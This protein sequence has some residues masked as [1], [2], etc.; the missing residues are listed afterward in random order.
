MA[1][2]RADAEALDAADPLAGFRERFVIDDPERLY[3]DGNSLGRLPV[4]TRERL[5][6][7]TAQW[8]TE[9]VSGWPEWLDAPRRVGDLLAEHVLGAPAGT[10][11]A[12]DS[13]T[14][15]LYKLAGALLPTCPEGALVTE[16]GNFPT[17]RYVLEGLARA[18]GREARCF[19]GEFRA[20]VLDGA[21]LLVLS[22]VDYRS[23]ALLD[24]ASTQAL[25]DEAGV[26]LI[27]D[28]SHS[29]GAVPIDL[30]GAGARL[31]VGCTYKYLNAG[32]GA[33]AYLYVA[34][35]L[36]E[37]LVSPIQGWFGQARQFDME[38]AY[39]PVPAI[40][41]F[42]A[43]T[44]PILGLAA[45]EEGV[46]VT[47]D[48]G[49]DRLREK[50]V[51][52]TELMVALADASLAPLG[53]SVASPRDPTARGSHVGLSH[54]QAWQ[55]CQALVERANVVPDF[56][57]PDVIRLAAAPLYTRYV[58]LYDAL[59]RLR[60]LVA[61]GAHREMPDTPGRVT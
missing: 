28:L 47:A 56:R 17:D 46:R 8:G 13:T 40:E 6:T 15:N 14:V 33:P 7:L 5:A 55:I 11:I 20:E 53:F 39:E 32:P 49:V 22:H 4:S 48:A 21:G 25:C 52:Q 34:E 35:E 31:A 16:R 2:T 10:V 9:L 57:G 24:M 26:P 43:G 42:L 58:D 59:Q 41:R 29:A 18:H 30:Q 27:W 19:D 50:S 38:R 60:D 44:P 45:V 12:C 51:A 61:L 1:V 3:L 54:P 36:I 37:T 23:G